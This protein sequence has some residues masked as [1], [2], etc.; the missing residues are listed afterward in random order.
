MSDYYAYPEHYS[1]GDYVQDGL[2][3]DSHSS[4]TVSDDIDRFIDVRNSQENNDENYAFVDNEAISRSE[5]VG[6]NTT[7]VEVM[8]N[9]WFKICKIIQ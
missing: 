5:V 4:G 8:F 7:D 2:E 1:A 3:I 6:E 9:F